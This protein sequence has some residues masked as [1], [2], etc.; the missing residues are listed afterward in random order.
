MIIPKQNK[1]AIAQLWSHYDVYL[2]QMF[3][4]ILKKYEEDF[5]PAT[6]EFDAAKQ[7]VTFLA[8]KQTVIDIKKI[9]EGTYEKN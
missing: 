9:L 3:D 7:Q 2:M 6:T 8:R 1:A 5:K 4:S